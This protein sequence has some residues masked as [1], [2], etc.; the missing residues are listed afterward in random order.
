MEDKDIFR[1]ALF[2]GYQKED[3]T[4]YI[5]SLENENE[6]IRIL[7]NKEKSDLKV[8]L[9][10]EKA[11]SEGLKASLEALHDKI[12][13]LE[14]EQPNSETH[15]PATAETEPEAG[16]L[17][18]EWTHRL[19]EER[20]AFLEDRRLWAD[21]LAQ[22]Q[23]DMHKL[24]Q[25]ELQQFQRTLETI[26]GQLERSARDAAAANTFQQTQEV[27]SEPDHGTADVLQDALA[28]EQPEES[29]T[30]STP[31]EGPPIDSASTE[32]EQP[33][34]SLAEQPRPEYLSEA[35]GLEKPSSSSESSEKQIHE[36]IL[37]TSSS[38]NQTQKRVSE[39]LLKLD[40][41]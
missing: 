37:K 12:S 13:R 6:A 27:S 20:K 2:G 40:H 9:E 41:F 3:V 26:Q 38:I 5:R 24:W 36:Y 16:I 23:A 1:T 33:L 39:L 29:P 11:A 8:Q 14:K 22:L 21:N 7:A 30:A 35:D 15:S 25:N 19:D 34:S 31:K 17:T 28:H 32:D 10:K 18:E 4:D